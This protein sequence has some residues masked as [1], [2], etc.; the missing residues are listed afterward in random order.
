MMTQGRIVGIKR[1]K[2]QF[3]SSDYYYMWTSNFLMTDFNEKLNKIKN[4]ERP[5]QDPVFDIID[6]LIKL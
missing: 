4:G 1:C 5:F 3:K 2:D 6:Q